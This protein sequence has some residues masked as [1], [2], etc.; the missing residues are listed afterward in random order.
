[1]PSTE[2]PDIRP[3]T[4]R[5]GLATTRISRSSRPL[6]ASLTAGPASRSAPAAAPALLV[7]ASS[8]R[9]RLSQ[10]A[11]VLVEA[12]AGLLRREAE[13]RHQH[14]GLDVAAGGLE[15]RLRLLRGDVRRQLHHA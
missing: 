10:D 8:T 1:M 7:S 15:R 13:R 12:R 11:A 5:R 14:R 6:T 3:S 2:V 9:Q 4:L